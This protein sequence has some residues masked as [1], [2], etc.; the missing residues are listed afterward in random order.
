VVL[1]AESHLIVLLRA[2]GCQQVENGCDG[3]SVDYEGLIG[4]IHKITLRGCWTLQGT[5]LYIW[6]VGEQCLKGAWL[7]VFVGESTE[8]PFKECFSY[9]LGSLIRLC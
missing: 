1:E 9:F 8:V 7:I 5:L 6:L 2:H 3:A 4:W